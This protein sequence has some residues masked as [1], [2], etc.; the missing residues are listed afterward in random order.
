MIEN[1][2]TRDQLLDKLSMLR[3]RVADMEA[4]AKLSDWYKERYR[5]LYEGCVDGYAAIDKDGFFTDFNSAFTLMMGYTGQELRGRTYRDVTPGKWHD[6]EEIILREQVMTRSY[7]HIFEKE[8]QRKDGHIFPAVLRTYLL[9]DNNGEYAGIWAFIRDI[10]D[11][12]QTENALR[13]SEERFY[14]AFSSSP[15]PTALTSIADGR[16]IDVNDSGLSLLEFTREEVIGHSILE[17][18]IWRNPETRERYIS[19]LLKEGSLHDE[20]IQLRTQSGAIKEILWSC[21]IIKINDE[22]AMLSIL[23]DVTERNRTEELQR[24]SEQKLSDIINF[25]PDATFAI[26]LQG[27]VIFWNRA[28]EEMTGVKAELMLGKSDYE[29]AMPFYGLRRPMLIDLILKKNKKIEKSYDFIIRRGNNLLLSEALIPSLNKKRVF[30]WGMASPLFDGKGHILGAIESIRD[31]TVHKQTQEA[32]T[33]REAELKNKAKELEA[34]NDAM[35]VL[36]KKRESDKKELE[37]KI[38]SNVKLLILPQIEKLK[39]ILKGR[40]A[41]MHIDIL[42][43]NLREI[44]SPFSRRLSSKYLNLTNKEIQIANFIREGKET[45]EIAESL[46]ISESTV[47]IHRYNIRKKLHLTKKHNLRTYLSSLG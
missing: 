23:Y 26:D 31:I 9:K 47:N 2:E 25:L 36:L 6:M 35:T 20:P 34:F 14:K 45:K 19:K 22:D 1:N 18:S 16:F 42:E 15:A 4:S 44:V 37:D 32:V 5:L 43:A 46:G 41:I 3:R 24:E 29:Y 21:E 10:T 38:I 27:R 28:M 33:K 11:R 39:E 13:V 40:K 12:K 8:F 17:L 7:S 30:L